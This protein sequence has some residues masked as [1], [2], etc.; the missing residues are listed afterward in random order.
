V[1]D[2]ISSPYV[3]DG[4]E[5]VIVSAAWLTDSVMEVDAEE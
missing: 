5:A 3:N 4:E 2:G 1:I